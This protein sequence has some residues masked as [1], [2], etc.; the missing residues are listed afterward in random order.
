V[1][2]TWCYVLRALKHQLLQ[3][4]VELENSQQLQLL[5]AQEKAEYEELAEA[6]DEESRAQAALVKTH[7]AALK[8]QQQDFDKK[9]QALQEQLAEQE[10]NDRRQQRQQVEQQTRSAAQSIVLSEELTRILIDHEPPIRYETLLTLKGIQFVRGQVVQAINT[11][12]GEVA[13]SEMPDD[14]NFDVDSFNRRVVNENFNRVICQELAKELDPFGEE[15][16]LIFCCTDLH[17]EMVKRL[18]DEAFTGLY[19]GDYQQSAVSRGQNHRP[20]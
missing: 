2:G 12:T 15:K 10:D 19:N 11:Q 8:Q 5:V 20:E 1:L 4:G 17:V 13:A 14:V 9:L 6:M 3:A 16:T 18:L 7:E